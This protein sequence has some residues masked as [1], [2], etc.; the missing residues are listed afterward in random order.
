MVKKRTLIELSKSDGRVYV[1]LS[2]EKIGSLFMKQAEKE[3]F[4]FGDGELP[5]KRSY[6]EIMAVNSDMTVNY[7][8]LCGRIA[9][10]SGAETVSGEKLLRVDYSEFISGKEDCSFKCHRK[11]RKEC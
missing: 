2:D 4:T 3:G 11:V 8:G 10:G 6:A 5:S 9:F 7:V 1:Y